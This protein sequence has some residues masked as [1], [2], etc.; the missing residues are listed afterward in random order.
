[1]NADGPV[2]GDIPR[3]NCDDLI[4]VQAELDEARATNKSLNRRCQLAEAAANLKVEEWGKR[5]KGQ[6]RAYVY[7]LGL[8]VGREAAEADLVRLRS[9]IEQLATEMRRSALGITRIT[10]QVVDDWADRLAALARGGE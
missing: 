7:Q 3:C 4:A 5:S 2:S 6:G 8:D 10:D 9:E 1:M